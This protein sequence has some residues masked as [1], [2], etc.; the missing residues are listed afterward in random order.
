MTHLYRFIQAWLRRWLRPHAA[1]VAGL[2]RANV[3]RIL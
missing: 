1:P 2:F 3:R